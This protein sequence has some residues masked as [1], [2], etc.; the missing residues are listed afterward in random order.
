VVISRKAAGKK[1]VQKA[2]S[3]WK[4]FST[5]YDHQSPSRE[6]RERGRNPVLVVELAG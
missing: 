2:S 1:F 3:N 4:R 5:I 6:N